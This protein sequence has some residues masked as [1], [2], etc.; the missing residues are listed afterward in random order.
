MWH[1]VVKAVQRGVPPTLAVLLSGV[2]G[3]VLH[4]EL[5]QCVAVGRR[6]FGW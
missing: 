3:A 2:A 4:P 5:V 6:L 1:I